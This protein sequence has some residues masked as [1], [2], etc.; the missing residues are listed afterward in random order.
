M[1]TLRNLAIGLIR[2]AGH[3]RIA[4]TIRKIN[5]NPLLLLTILGL[6]HTSKPAH[7]QQK[8][9]CA[10]PW[11]RGEAHQSAQPVMA[12]STRLLRMPRH[13][14]R[15]WI[16]ESEADVAGRALRES[17]G[18]HFDVV[19]VVHLGGLLARM[20]SED[21][22]GVLDEASLERDRRRPGT[23]CRVRDSRSLRRRSGPVAT[24]SSGGP[25]S[26]DRAARCAAARCLAP[27]PPL[28][29]TGSSPCSVSAAARWSTWP[30]RW[31]RTRQWRPRR[32]P[33][34]HR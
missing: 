16:G 19:V 1:A 8:R 21:P 22:A 26:A 17:R 18:H 14:S 4:A 11:V 6:H 27:M 2:Q 24:T 30:V 5:N 10:S 13:L 3:T 12:T 31:A 29:T 25:S 15:V 20:G 32:V 7:D 34:P 23:A 28:R 33:R 9:L